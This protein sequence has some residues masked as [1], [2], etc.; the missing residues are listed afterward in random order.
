MT[1]STALLAAATLLTGLSA[2]LFAT[3]SYVVMPGLRRSDDAEFVAAMRGINIAILNPV[4]A[5]VFGGSF[6]A[7]VTAL[8]A[9][10]DDPSRPWIFAALAA[11]VVGAFVIT[12]AVNVPLNNA[13]EAGAGS[14][15]VLR[16][17]FEVRWV[18]SNHARSA[19][20]VAAFGCLVLAL[21][22]V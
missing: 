4:F 19:L 9:G 21:L 15:T 6:V 3:F 17:A 16:R 1:T 12:F 10:W 5:L 14:S 8:V 7:T 20:T 18:G 22:E 11:Y 13:L 2:G